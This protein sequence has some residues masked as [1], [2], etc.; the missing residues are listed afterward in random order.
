MPLS[1]PEASEVEEDAVGGER[2]YKAGS[3]LKLLLVGFNTRALAESCVRADYCFVS[4]DSFGDLDHSLLGPVFSPCRPRPGFPGGG[5]NME[6]LVEWGIILAKQQHCD[7]L[8]YASG[9]ENRP[10]LL[11]KLISESGCQLYGNTSSALQQVRDAV[12]LSH[13]LRQSGFHAPETYL[14][15]NRPPDSDRRWLIKPLKSGGGHGIVPADQRRT[16]PEG[17]VFQEYISG[18]PCSFSFV[19]DGNNCLILGI[20]EQ[21]IAAKSYTGRDFGY[22]GNLFPLETSDQKKLYETVAS[23][24]RWLTANYGL[25]GLNGVDFILQGEDCWVIEVNPRYSASMELFERAYEFPM[26]KLHVLACRG[27]WQ[28][29]KRLVEGLTIERT[30]CQPKCV[31]IKKVIYTKKSKRALPTR[32]EW[33]DEQMQAWACRMHDR[34]LRDLPYPGDV[35]GARRP[36]ATAIVS[37]ASKAECVNKSDA[38]SA[39]M[40]RQLS[41]AG[42]PS[43]R[44]RN[45]GECRWPI[46]PEC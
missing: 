33:T 46:F 12:A 25:K 1:D 16:I 18:K 26:V 11:S 42:Q 17:S 10:E 30:F 5:P 8:A 39:L 2:I 32:G 15:D 31:W 21:L 6:S 23:I 40:M 14:P 3:N 34:G 20:T 24:A 28:E 29:V 44:K 41:P 13:N 35:I 19:S 45:K 43:G 4:L 22:V 7:S 38:L 9:L 27:D 36:V 37:G